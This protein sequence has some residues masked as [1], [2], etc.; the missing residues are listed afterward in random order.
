LLQAKTLGYQIVLVFV[1]TNN[2]RINVRRV[3]VRVQQ[4]GHDVPTD[5]IISRYYRSL[6]LLP[7]AVEIAD[8]SYIFDNSHMA[9]LIVHVVNGL[10]YV[11]KEPIPAWIK[12]ALQIQ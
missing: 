2:P 3:A 5:K 9:E 8:V 10:R 12:T 4:G 11:V 1:A 7:R 6:D